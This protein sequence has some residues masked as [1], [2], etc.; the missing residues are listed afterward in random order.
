MGKKQSLPNALLLVCFWVITGCLVVTKGHCA[1][2]WPFL[3]L[4]LF[5]SILFFF[6]CFVRV[7]SLLLRAGFL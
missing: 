4:L 2:L 1:D 6:I 7:G 3:A 5:V